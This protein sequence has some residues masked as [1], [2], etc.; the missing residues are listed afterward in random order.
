MKSTFTSLV[1]LGS[2]FICI[3]PSPFVAPY[4]SGGLS[5]FRRAE[6]AGIGI[7]LE[8]E[9]IIFIND[10]PKAQTANATEVER[11]KGKTVSPVDK[12]IKSST[13]E[14]QL[15][16]ELSGLEKSRG[17]GNL[18][19]EFIVDGTKVKLGNKKAAKVGAEITK[20]LMV[21]GTR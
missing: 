2:A 4:P 8:T 19:A 18:R 12:T 14:W 3:H 10:A 9:G 20:F 7:E 13:E 16:A 17:I 15:T 21:R 6:P 11:I 5:F 1:L